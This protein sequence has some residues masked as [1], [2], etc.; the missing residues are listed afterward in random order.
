[1]KASQFNNIISYQNRPV[2]FNAL[3]DK[4][5][6][7]DPLLA[8]MVETAKAEHN[9]DQI[10]DYHPD[11]FD[12]LVADGFI[13]DEEKDEVE[14]VRQIMR[15]VDSDDSQYHLVINP[16]M[17]CNFKCW[18][19]YESHIKDSKMS[20]ETIESIQKHL[21]IVIANNPQIKRLFISWFGGEPMLF[22]DQVIIP[23]LK[24]TKQLTD[25][26]DIYFSSNF[27][28]N[29]FL[30]KESMIEDFKL[31]NIFDFQITLDG[32]KELHDTVR[33]VTKNRG[34]YDE[35]ISNIK[36]LCNNQMEATMR[37]NYTKTNLPGIEDILEDIKDLGA[38]ARQY[39]TIKFHKVW[40]EEDKFLDGRV[41]ELIAFYK[42]HGF[43]A[44]ANF[45][46]DSLKNSCYA[47]KKNHATIN[48]NGEVFKCT[49]RDFK[50]EN[51]EGVLDKDGHLEWNEKFY[52]RMDIK[53]KN[54]P[55][56]RC[57]ILPLCN[58]GCSQHAVEALGEDYC[59]FDF[60]ESAKKDVIYKKFLELVS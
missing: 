30:I 28:T 27:T 55:C 34:S 4:F 20:L 37:I 3:T 5:L 2:I 14:T 42:S 18:Y 51:R 32:N 1:M 41:M 29:G 33:Y 8:Q 40:Q 19:C 59:V 10:N 25:Q 39:L 48:Y 17:N 47:D 9:M 50:T 38:E 44:K 24:R 49:A 45:V 22:Y 13:V 58:G 46:P 16:T 35:I 53:L 7:L 43:S 12:R 56:Q 52:N 6:L 60:D 36:L 21:E 15:S 54:K 31:Y 57:S 23:I 11:F 26:H